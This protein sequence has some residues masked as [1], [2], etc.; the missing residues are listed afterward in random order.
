MNQARIEG[1]EFDTVS[2]KEGMAR[3][4][5]VVERFKESVD[6]WGHGVES[7]D[8]AENILKLGLYT[9]WTALHDI[10]FKL[11][12]VTL[13]HQLAGWDY[14]AREVIVLIA[15]PKGFTSSDFGG[16]EARKKSIDGAKKHVFEEQIPDKDLGLP[17]QFKRRVPADRIIGYINLKTQEF[18][19]NP[20][21]V[22]EI[23]S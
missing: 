8:T 2:Y 3:V 18:V 4:V 6:V 13:E 12:S 1:V 5:T 20:K 19:L 9:G 17:N 15:L 23:Q 22:P 7:I 16:Y 10:A 21:F 14:G 11:E